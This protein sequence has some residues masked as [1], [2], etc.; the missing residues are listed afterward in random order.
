MREE[1]QRQEA[2][3]RTIFLAWGAACTLAFRGFVILAYLRLAA[4]AE[5][6]VLFIEL[7]RLIQDAE[8]AQGIFFIIIILIMARYFCGRVSSSS[9][10]FGEW[11]GDKPTPFSLFQ[12]LNR[13]Q[14]FAKA[15]MLT[16]KA[17]PDCIF[18]FVCN[19]SLGYYY[20]AAAWDPGKFPQ[21]ST[22]V[23]GKHIPSI[24]HEILCSWENAVFTPSRCYHGHQEYRVCRFHRNFI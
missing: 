4:F 11:L 1:T 9:C 15:G 24:Q 18:I 12:P 17:F 10:S 21:G 8:G 6:W 2:H 14:V 19:H 5:D 3:C 23:T 20:S 7:E 16:F 13:K 22:S